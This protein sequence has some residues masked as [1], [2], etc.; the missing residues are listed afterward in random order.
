MAIVL[1]IGPPG[2]GK[3]T[4]GKRITAKFGWRVISTGDLLRAHMKA[5]DEIGKRA[6]GFVNRGELVPDTLLLEILAKAMPPPAADALPV[7]LDG[8]PRN[9]S[10]ARSLDAMKA[11]PVRLAV[12]LD[13]AFEIVAERIAKRQKLEGRTDDSPEKAR[14][15]LKVYEKDTNPILDFY[16]DKGLYRR[17]EANRSEEDVFAQLERTFTEAGLVPGARR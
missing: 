14:Y 9:L 13:I 5:G 2:S 11:H 15:R 16:R 8:F 3:G 17:V 4:Q 7:I 10:Q 6:E 1:L 12:H